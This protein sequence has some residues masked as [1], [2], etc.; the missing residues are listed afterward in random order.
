MKKHLLLYFILLSGYLT[1][2]QKISPN[3][4]IGVRLGGNISTVT[5]APSISQEAKFGM[6]GG[7]VFKHI[8]E[9]NWGVQVEL[10]YLQAGW[11]ESLE[12]NQSYSRTFGYLQVPVLT[13]LYF[14]KKNTKIFFNF[15][16][17]LSYLISDKETYE[18]I[19]EEEK[20]LHYG[21]D[22]LNKFEIGLT[23]GLGV[24]KK[25]S[26]GDFLIE[27]RGNFAL[28]DFFKESEWNPFL[29]SKNLTFE[30]SLAYMLNI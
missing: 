13:H 8:E 7:L 1:Y 21:H 11:A 27:A 20:P 4:Y 15:G 26:I 28:S 10:N 30:L 23:T 17:Y 22:I 16:P 2:T 18:N 5:F 29:Y 9:K 25:T 14:G 3:S 12:E 19:P 6:I 24:N